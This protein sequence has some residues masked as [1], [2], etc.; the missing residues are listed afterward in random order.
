VL[1]YVLAVALAVAILGLGLAA[2]D[3]GTAVRGETELESA[4]E[5]VDRAAVDLYGNE[6]LA[7]G[8]HP[9]PQ[10]RVD[11]DLPGAGYTRDAPEYVTFERAPGQN[12]THVTYRFP[13]RAERTHRIDAPLIHAGQQ[14]FRLDGYTGEVTL[15]L[16]L[17]PDDDS[18]PVV[19][20]TVDQ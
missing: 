12:L 20:V 5:A 2:V 14:T 16:R 1:R 15:T 11:L 7:L 17:V 8:A 13:G 18:R 10:R 9:P 4:L 6:Q 3:H 19:A